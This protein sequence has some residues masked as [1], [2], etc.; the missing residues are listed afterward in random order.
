MRTMA[1]E[2]WQAIALTHNEVWMAM[3]GIWRC[4]VLRMRPL[5]R[6]SWAFPGPGI[7]HFIGGQAGVFPARRWRAVQYQPRL[8]R[9]D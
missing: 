3:G 9:Q 5:R 7:V 6:T 2:N 4:F 1:T 8:Y